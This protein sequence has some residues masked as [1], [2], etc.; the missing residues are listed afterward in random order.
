M[1]FPE[2]TTCLFYSHKK[3]EGRVRVYIFHDNIRSSERPSSIVRRHSY[4]ITNRMISTVSAASR[5]SRAVKAATRD[6]LLHQHLVRIAVGC[7]KTRHLSLQS[8]SVRR[9]PLG[10]ALSLDGHMSEHEDHED[11]AEH[12]ARPR[13]QRSMSPGRGRQ[14][15]TSANGATSFDEATEYNGTWNTPFRHSPIRSSYDEDYDEWY[16]HGSPATKTTSDLG[17]A[18]VAVHTPG[19]LAGDVAVNPNL[20]GSTSFTSEGFVDD[21]SAD[22][23]YVEFEED[24]RILHEE[25]PEGD[26]DSEDVS[27]EY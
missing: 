9:Y 7:S 21:V 17:E 14:Y 13:I 3:A 5:L 24:W 10:E 25:M 6:T 22:K 8:V 2:S 19:I 26:A 23:D 4:S 27:I 16:L 1:G 20:V 15:T 12:D 11:H 18:S